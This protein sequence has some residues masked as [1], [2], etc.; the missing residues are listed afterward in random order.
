[1]SVPLF[2]GTPCFEDVFVS[3]LLMAC[4]E[5]FFLV[6]KNKLKKMGRET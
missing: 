5:N 6:F 4:S 3:V 1:M 2:N